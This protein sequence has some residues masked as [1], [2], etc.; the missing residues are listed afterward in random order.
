MGAVTVA[1]NMAGRGVDIILGGNPPSADEA[2]RV[3][4]VGGLYVIGTE[5]HEAR[6]IDN[7]L[8][9]RAGRQG[10]SGSSQF[11]VSLEDDLM[12]IFGGDKVKNLMTRLG[13]PENQPIENSFISRAIESAQSKIEGYHFDA[14]KHV[15]EYDDVMNR[16]REVI[17]KKRREIMQAA[18]KNLREE[19]IAEP[20]G[21]HPPKFSKKTWEGKRGTTQ[22]DLKGQVLEMVRNEIEKIVEFHTSSEDPMDWNIEE[23]SEVLKTIFPVPQN[24]HFK[25]NELRGK[26]EEIVKYLQGLA[27]EIYDKKEKGLGEEAT[28]EIE[29]LVSLRN[30]DMLWMNHLDEMEYLRDSVKLRAY[31]QRDPLVEYK[32]EAHKMFENL[33]AAIQSGIVSTIYKVGI[34]GQSEAPRQVYEKKE[35]TKF[36]KLG[37]G[38][39][40]IIENQKTTSRQDKVGRNDPCPCGSG[41]KYKKCHGV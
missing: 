34:V 36:D 13:V 23:I 30:I 14:R 38:N 20:C 27:S 22:K 1:T 25:L 3:C 9:G 8:R 12:R 33:L 37:R 40:K 16:Q 31:G 17:Y 4:K 15:L 32:N 18:Y 7:Q 2:D 6:R 19:V 28:R 11:F 21:T 24:I 29:K 35:I 5:R 39:Q 26:K 10:D 41:K